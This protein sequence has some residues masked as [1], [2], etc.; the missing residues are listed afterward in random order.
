MLGWFL[1]QSNFGD[2][3]NETSQKKKLSPIE[4]IDSLSSN[5]RRYFNFDPLF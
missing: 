3:N 5:I 1:I 2:Q 4:D